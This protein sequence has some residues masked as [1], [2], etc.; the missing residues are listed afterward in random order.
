[1]IISSRRLFLILA[2]VAFVLPASRGWGQTNPEL[3]VKPW[4]AG[5]MV[6]TSTEAVIES[7]A[8]TREQP[9]YDVGLSSY[10]AF[11]RVRLFPDQRATPLLG[12]DVTY[13]NVATS[14][15]ALPKH[16]W[17][18]TVG[19]AQPI[20]EINKWFVVLTGAAGYAGDSPFSDP[21]AT[22]YTGNLI[23]GKE[24]SKDKAIV[25]AL[26]Y[27][28]NRAFLPDT[29][30][31]G[32]AYADRYN[33]RLTYVIGAPLNSIT[34]EPVN[35][36]QVDVGWELL[37]TFSG[38]VGW[39]FHKHYEVFTSYTDRL[40]AF[41]LSNLPS[42]RRLFLQEHRAEIGFR[43]NPTRLVRFSV[44]GG[45]A[46]GQEFS[47]GFDLRGTNSLR[48]LRDGPFGQALLEIQL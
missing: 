7:S 31:P 44:G 21:H 34:Y 15:P 27:D 29:P 40:S 39:E 4:E 16:L 24:F 3:L 14:D 25:I 26:N 6:D 17:D 47:T 28:G 10:H 23:V 9:K 13:F 45:W 32:I 33:E 18:G 30:I 35:G 41:H 37:E 42:D 2:A 11:G 43:F 36:L 48:H 12:Y 38:R 22:Y 46:F 19:F 20:G 1:M 5:Q 8:P